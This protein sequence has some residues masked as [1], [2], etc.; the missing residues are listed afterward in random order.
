MRLKETQ[1]ALN[2][3]GKRVI[4]QAKQN[5]TKK[6]KNVNK[7]LYDSLFYKAKVMP[8]RIDVFFFMEK[9]GIFQDKGVKGTKSNYIENRDTP[10]S[11]RMKMPPREPL[12]EWA[13]KRQIRLRD[14]KG[15]FAK[16]NYNTIGY[17]LQKSIF[18]KGIRASMFFTKPFENEFKK[19]PTE[20]IEQYGLDIDEF[21]ELTT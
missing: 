12:I 11:Y 8:N 1:K 13:K 3:F 14:D 17:L 10:F 20:I 4:K 16:G 21:L 18:E 9:Y 6:K 2:T 15:R 5:L 19:L 7:K